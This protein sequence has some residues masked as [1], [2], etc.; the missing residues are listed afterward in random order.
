VRLSSWCVA[1][2]F[3]SAPKKWR[4]TSIETNFNNREIIPPR[5]LIMRRNGIERLVRKAKSD[6]R[7]P[8]NLNYYSEEDFRLAERKYLRL[9]IIKGE[10]PQPMSAMR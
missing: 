3:I 4:H 7:I 10:Y 6:F 1:I 5:R 2:G 8:E 9:C